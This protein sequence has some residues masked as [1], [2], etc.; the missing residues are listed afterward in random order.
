MNELAKKI[1]LL[2]MEAYYETACA[3]SE[4]LVEME[5]RF[6]RFKKITFVV[7]VIG[8]LAWAVLFVSI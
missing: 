8:L 4:Q 1:E 7:G 5:K 2:R 6:K 3:K